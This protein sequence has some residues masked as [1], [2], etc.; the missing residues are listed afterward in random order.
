MMKNKIFLILIAIFLSLPLIAQTKLGIPEILLPWKD[1]VL[2]GV[3]DSLCPTPYNNGDE[4]VCVWQT[5]LKLQ[6]DGRSGQFTQI[7][8]NYVE[9]WIQLPGNNE[10]WPE[11]VKINNKLIPVE[12]HQEGP[13]LYLP[14][15]EYTIQGQFTWDKL[16]DYVQISPNTGAVMLTLNG[17]SIPQPERN[18][19]GKI[20]LRQQIDQNETEKE[21]TLS[22]KIYR[23][24]Q[25]HIPQTDST[26]IRLQATGKMREISIGPVLQPDTL[27]LEV[28]SDLPAKLEDNGTLRLQIKPGSWEIKVR[29]R[30]LTKHDKLT[31]QKHLSPWPQ[32][33]IWA[34]QPYNDLR[35]VE[36]EGAVSIDPQQTDMPDAWKGL[37]T[38]LMKPDTSLLIVEKRRG[39]EKRSE[40]LQL[41]RKMWLDF[42]GKGYITQ[43]MLSG[44]AQNTSR[45]RMEPPYHLSSATI[46]GQNKLITQ[47]DAND[48]PGIEIRNGQLNLTGVSR[49]IGRPFHLPAVGWDVDI[50]SLSSTLILPPGWMLLGAWGVDSVTN[51]WVQ[52]WTLL[53]L[54]LVLIMAAATAKLLGVRWGLLALVTL[55]L[56]YRERGA[57]IY[58]WLNLIAALGLLKVLPMGNAR[59]W[60]LYYSRLSLVVL[61]LIALPFMVKQIREAIYPQLTIPNGSPIALMAKEQRRAIQGMVAL[62]ASPRMA[63]ESMAAGSAMSKSMVEGNISEMKD[64]A[65]PIEDYDPNAKIQTGPGI[66]TWYWDEFQLNWNG[67]VLK[68]QK[69]TLWV[70]PSSVTSCLKLLQVMLMFLFM[71]ALSTLW[72][73]NEPLIT[74][75]KSLASS[76]TTLS[77]LLALFFTGNLLIGIV[78]STARAD[79]PN[80][81]LLGDLKNRLLEPPHC[82]P[83]CADISRLDVSTTPEQLTLKL[84]I[85]AAVKTAI[86]LPSTIGKWMPQSVMVDGVAAKYLQL[87]KQQL[88]LQLEPGVHEVILQGFIGKQDKFDVIIPLKPKV[89]ETNAQG[90]TIDGVFRRQLQGE[91]LY[92]TRVKSAEAVAASAASTFTSGQM[93]AFVVLTRTLKLGFDWEIF[94][95]LR[96]EAP[97]Q[98]A[99]D[100]QIPLIQ[101]E[102]VLADNVE[103][104]EDKIFVSIGEN[105]NH[106]SWKS[107]LKQMPEIK[108]VAPSQSNLKEIWQLDAISQ[109]HCRFEGIPIIHQQNPQ[110]RWFP[111]WFPW[112]G[113]TLTIFVTR[114]EAVSGSTL[115]IENSRLTVVPGKRATDN[116]LNFLARSSLGGTHTIKI[117]SQAKLQDVLINGLSQPLNVKEGEITVPLHPGDQQIDVKWQ[118]PQGI[119]HYYKTPTASLSQES[120]NALIN[121]QLGKDRWILALGGP[122]VG[123]AVLFWGVLFIIIIAAVALGKF[124]KAPL[125]IWQ[126]ILLGIGI[127]VATPIAALIVVVWFFAM[128]KRQEAA[129]QISEFSFQVIQVGLSL[130]TLLFVVSLFTSISTG[131]LGTPQMQLGSPY[132]NFVQSIFTLPAYFQ[133]QWY[134]DVAASELPHAWVLSLPLYVYRILMLLWALWLAFSLIKW[135]RWGWQCF[136]AGGLWYRQPQ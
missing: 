7:A 6:L 111:T 8:T 88:W 30:F 108:L 112:P 35:L 136:S 38:Y 56:I 68:D 50:K 118:L 72:R 53:D 100:I 45:L 134:Q 58:S 23:L 132:V 85:H 64:Q 28:L 69:L 24:I 102:S 131:L 90:W 44:V 18:V 71:Y 51:A 12:T 110:G 48:P 123:P 29:S 5:S 57:P 113:E 104:K 4:H 121:L 89:I 9:G 119:S 20:W 39:Q 129:L 22:L 97:L 92:F 11:Q 21:D 125:T 10:N 91:S 135:L 61:V 94:N 126:W 78:P 60:I 133:L 26:V 130:L 37:P 99:I 32:E 31:L 115:T 117:P 124:A 76:N 77:L 46:D 101:G 82:L 75:K 1:W 25:D 120:S 127:A 83:E 66:P 106:I 63:M 36:I 93:P 116:T 49:I 107:K 19:D 13:A 96:R 105:Q 54:F 79:F 2:Y 16:P 15:G 65:R 47:L 17:E 70:L 128:R 87:E 27:P 14:P 109:W 67:P 122:A 86:P 81:E 73:Q 84:I 34:F 55:T 40:E 95:E 42:S 62:P 43:D 114:P 74:K 98:G 52:E 103:V 41:Q 33:E 59:T 80:Q 3:E